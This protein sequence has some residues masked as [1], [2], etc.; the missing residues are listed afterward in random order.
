MPKNEQSWAILGGGSSR[1][2]VR[3]SDEKPFNAQTYFLTKPSLSGRGKALAGSFPRKLADHLDE[4]RK[5][6]E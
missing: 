5:A 3:G 2:V 4:I 6:A 1:R